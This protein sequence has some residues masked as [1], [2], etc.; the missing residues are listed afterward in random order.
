MEILCAIL[1]KEKDQKAAFMVHL[2]APLWQGN[3][4][5]LCY[6][7]HTHLLTTRR[8]WSN[9]PFG[10]LY[11]TQW[12]L[13][14][15]GNSKIRGLGWTQKLHQFNLYHGFDLHSQSQ[16]K[17]WFHRFLCSHPLASG[18]SLPAEL[19]AIALG[20]HLSW[21]CAKNPTNLPT[22][23]PSSATRGRPLDFCPGGTGAQGSSFLPAHSTM[24]MMA[25]Q[26]LSKHLRRGLLQHSSKGCQTLS[27][28]TAAPQPQG[29]QTL[30]LPHPSIMPG[31]MTVG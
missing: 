26:A 29:V 6:L 24:M 18:L 7:P 8:G 25:A 13:K 12:S 1:M 30:P 22:H 16:L 9:L 11:L 19:V 31:H 10:R 17:V 20:A 3:Q 4:R 2:E 28:S 21:F 27:V 14:A 5:H 23:L 15:F